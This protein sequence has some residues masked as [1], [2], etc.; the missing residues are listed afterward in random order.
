MTDSDPYLSQVEAHVDYEDPL[1]HRVTGLPR[2]PTMRDRGGKELLAAP[3]IL[4][5]KQMR[6]EL[7]M[8]QRVPYTKLPKFVQKHLRL[9]WDTSENTAMRA[10]VIGDVA[11]FI[12][13]LFR[14]DQI[15]VAM[16]DAGYDLAARS[17]LVRFRAAVDGFREVA[18]KKLK[19]LGGKWPPVARSER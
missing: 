12:G 10:M 2:S 13:W 1:A 18:E 9:L 19:K 3:F 6:E 16:I 4:A 8:Q 7:F 11:F 17:T 14:L 5:W 15:D